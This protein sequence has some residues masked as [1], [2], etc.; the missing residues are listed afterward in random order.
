MVI[1]K[2]DE[3]KV[4]TSQIKSLEKVLDK[5]EIER[6]NLIDEFDLNAQEILGKDFVSK[7]LNSN[8]NTANGILKVKDVLP[9]RIINTKNG[10]VSVNYTGILTHIH[11]SMLEDKEVKEEFERKL[12]EWFKSKNAYY[13]KQMENTKTFDD[14]KDYLPQT[15]ALSTLALTCFHSKPNMFLRDVQLLAAIAMSNGDIAE[16]GTGEGKTLAAVPVLYFYSLRGKGAHIVTANSYLSKRDYEEVRPIFESLGQSVGFVPDTIEDLARI[17]GYSTEDIPYDKKIE[18]EKKLHQVKKKA[19]EKDI[20]YASK[21][22]VAFDYLRDGTCKKEED[23]LQR[24]T[25]PAFALIDEVDDALI[26]DAQCPYILSEDSLI[27]ADGMTVNDLAK[28]VRVP[29]EDIDSKTNGKY[30][31]YDKISYEE[32]RNLCISLYSKEI[33][34]DQITYQ[35]RAQRFF[36]KT[37]K[38]NMYIVTDDNEF[39]MNPLE[40]YDILT[41]DEKEIYLAGNKEQEERLRHLA[42]EIKSQSSMILYKEQNEYYIPDRTVEKYLEYFYYAFE[43]N[44]KIKENAHEIV[45][46]PN[47]IENIDYS[48]VNGNV[49][50]TSD[51]AKRIVRDENHPTFND[52][53]NKFISLVNEDATGA[54]H[55]F[56]NAIYANIVMQMPRDYT[57]VDGKVKVVKNGRV[58]EGS[59]YSNGL[60]EAIELKEKID[61]DK[62]TK[63]NDT[64]ASITQKDFYSR[65]DVFAGMTGTSSKSVFEEVFQKDTVQIP[66]ND[67]YNYYS[68]RLKHNGLSSSKKPIGIHKEETRYA[69]DF[70]SKLKLIIASIEE[71]VF[72]EKHQPVLVVVSNPKELSLI[73]D[74]LNKRG[75]NH[76][77]LDANTDKSKEAEIIARAGLPGA[78]TLSTE[79]AGRGTD[80]K[81]GG[82]RDTIINIATERRIKNVERKIGKPLNLT[83]N[84]RDEV[85]QSVENALMN[86]SKNLLWSAESEE[87]ERER[88]ESIGLKVLSSGY[89][90]ISRIDRQLEGRCGRNGAKGVCERYASPSDLEYIGVK[91]MEE[92]VTP[93]EY[94][95]KFP[96]AVNGAIMLNDKAKKNVEQK[97]SQAQAINEKI[98]SDNIKATQ[99]LS[100]NAE[101]IIDKYRSRRREILLGKVDEKLEVEKMLEEVVDNLITSYLIEGDINKD[102]VLESMEQSNLVLDI[103]ALA[104]EAKQVLGIEFDLDSLKETNANIIEFRNAILDYALQ[105]HNVAYFTD[106]KSARENDKATLLQVNSYMIMSI[107]TILDASITQKSL[108]SLTMDDSQDQLANEEFYKSCQRK[109]LEKEKLAIKNAFGKILSKEEERSLEFNKY[110]LFGKTLFY[111]A[112]DKTYEFTESK[113]KENDIESLKTFRDVREK[114]EQESKKE[115]EKVERRSTKLLE[116]GQE[117]KAVK[118]YANLM[119]RPMFFAKVENGEKMMLTEKMPEVILSRSKKK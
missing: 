107:P 58:I 85:R 34:P 72:S 20:T 117:D 106:E 39:G 77:V 111:D 4:N 62:M 31:K 17:E 19:Y 119:V 116:K 101:K 59:T 44:K 118:L 14:I 42:E 7:F 35:R 105:K 83:S 99:E 32:A 40:L 10:R 63:V 70:E 82:D 78:V 51:A 61:S 69:S 75:I 60:Q 71:S 110:S 45:N 98:I 49:F 108:T 30:K 87:E 64:V 29:Y 80:I 86:S 65:Y 18:L 43:I 104:I 1:E 6:K 11:K 2:E 88:L 54:L 57:I 67:F 48:I 103:A 109:R 8:V 66:K 76:E 100:R 38:P 28:L 37:I 68:K 22:A 25:K 33:V 113:I 41:K 73:D 21:S 47:Y 46:D 96:K 5:I 12:S 89:F 23:L 56:N 26:D 91:N 50:L 16:L 36:E 79:M 27:Y 84:E 95:S 13:K 3:A 55:Y 53:Y 97:I 93:Q 81:L 102:D 114:V 90:K 52:D 24:E 74:E 15:Y 9:S 112:N 115:L 92:N 94:F